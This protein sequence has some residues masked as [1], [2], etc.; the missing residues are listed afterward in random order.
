MANQF[1]VR[2][3][4]ADSG[5][6]GLNAQ[7]PDVA[8]ILPR[9]SRRPQHQ[10]TSAVNARLRWWSYIPAVFVATVATAALVL[11]WAHRDEGHLTPDTGLG[12]WLGIIGGGAMLLLL[13]YPLRKRVRLLRSLGSVSVWFRTHMLLGIVG[14]VLIL[15]HTNFKLGSTNSNVALFSMLTVAI[16]GII[17]RYIYAKIHLGLYGRRATIGDLLQDVGVLTAALGDEIPNAERVLRPLKVLSDDFMRPRRGVFSAAFAFFSLGFRAAMCRRRVLND[18]FAMIDGLAQQQSWPRRK[19]IQHRANVRRYL[20]D[21]FGA[22][23]RLA[24]FAIF[25]RIF[26]AWHVLHLPLFFILIFTAVLHVIAVHIY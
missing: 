1:S 12:Y 9:R 23:K 3:A 18:A 17:G 2:A 14:P 6:A 20:Q 15:F 13:L 21:Y 5:D 24:R 19:R 8:E 26:A 4:T 10:M 22:A 7:R 16:S 25:E 11:G